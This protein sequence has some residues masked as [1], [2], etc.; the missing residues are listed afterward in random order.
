PASDGGPADRHH[1]RDGRGRV[2]DGTDGHGDIRDN[3]VRLETNQL[4]GQR[5]KAV[6]PAQ[7]VSPVDDEVLS[8][9]VTEVTKPLAKGLGRV[10]AGRIEVHRTPMRDSFPACASAASGATTRPTVRMTASPSSRN[11]HLG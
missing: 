3:D 7:L 2:D 10:R 9:D 11:G 4:G 5:G 8:F 1:D 6:V